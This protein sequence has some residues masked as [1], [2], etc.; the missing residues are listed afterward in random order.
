MKRKISLVIAFALSFLMMF[1][2]IAQAQGTEVQMTVPISE[3]ADI[4]VVKV[5]LAETNQ[6][7][8]PPPQIKVKVRILEEGEEKRRSQDCSFMCSSGAKGYF[9]GGTCVDCEA[10]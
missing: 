7:D 1:G 4:E 10:Q 9:L 8:S 6:A 3:S 2:S 5:P